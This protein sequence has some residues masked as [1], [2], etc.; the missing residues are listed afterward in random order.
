MT[1]KGVFDYNWN[2]SI[3][4]IENDFKKKNYTD[5]NITENK[6]SANMDYNGIPANIHVYFYNGKIFSGGISVLHDEKA[7]FINEFKKRDFFETEDKIYTILKST[8]GEPQLLEEENKNEN[9]Q[10]RSRVWNFKNNCSIKLNM[11]YQKYYDE[12]YDK[13][14]DYYGYDPIY[15]YSYLG[16]SFLNNDLINKKNKQENK[17]KK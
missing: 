3:K 15:G 4:D 12:D 6:I 10:E 17:T 8:Y 16:F 5:I 13:Y 7:I 14:D 9:D 1:L 11:S 2:T